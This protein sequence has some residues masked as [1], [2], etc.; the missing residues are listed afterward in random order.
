MKNIF[1]YLINKTTK[2]KNK[3]TYYLCINNIADSYDY[4]IELCKKVQEKENGNIKV[5]FKDIETYTEQNCELL[6]TYEWYSLVPNTYPSFALGKI[7]V[8]PR[9]SIKAYAIPLKAY[10]TSFKSYLFDKETSIKIL[11]Y[12]IDN[13]NSRTK[14]IILMGNKRVTINKDQKERFGNLNYTVKKMLNVIQ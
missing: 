2:E 14:V 5:T 3:E 6:E 1:E 11:K 10:N 7:D 8:Q 12:I 13:T 9:E 4:N